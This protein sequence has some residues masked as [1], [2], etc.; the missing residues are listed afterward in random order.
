M[1]LFHGR[2]LAV[3]GDAD[4]EYQSASVAYSTFSRHTPCAMNGSLGVSEAE[5]SP[6]KCY[7]KVGR[8]R[9]ECFY[10]L[11]GLPTQTPINT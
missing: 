2:L 7:I 8:L 6:S 4:G 11:E 1:G 10:F 3:T 5:R 9:R